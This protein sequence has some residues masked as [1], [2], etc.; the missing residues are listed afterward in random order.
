MPPPNP[1][2]PPRVADVRLRGGVGRAY[3]PAESSR[4]PPL[5]VLLHTAPAGEAPERLCAEAGVVVLALRPASPQKVIELVR[6]VAAH[7]HELDADP[8]RVLVAGEAA[9][10]VVAQVRASGVTVTGL[11][12]AAA[13]ELVDEL[14]KKFPRFFR[15]GVEK[16]DPGPT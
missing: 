11:A 15:L 2:P 7:A 16:P 5:V 3:W 1:Q 12:G 9:D 6:W 4:S 8:D 13:G 14:T 10:A